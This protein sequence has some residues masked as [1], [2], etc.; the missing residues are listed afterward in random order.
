M[1]PGT[2]KMARNT[3][4]ESE[5]PKPEAPRIPSNVIFI[6]KKSPLVYATAAFMQITSGNDAILRARGRAIST[7]VDSVEILKHRFLK[8]ALVIKEIKIGTEVMPA[9]EEGFRDRNVSTIEIT[10]QKS[11]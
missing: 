3:M 1:I 7:A 11:G 8:D 5:G 9:R 6:G 4:A 2:P 10:L